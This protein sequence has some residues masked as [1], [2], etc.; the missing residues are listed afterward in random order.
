MAFGLAAKLAHSEMEK[1]TRR[2][3]ELRDYFLEALQKIEPGIIINGSLEQ[4]IVNNLNIVFP[5]ID[6]G[7]LLLSLH[8]LGVYVSSGS[9][10]SAGSKETSYVIKALGVD[11]ERYGIIRFSF[12]LP[13][14]K[15]EVEYLLKYLPSI[16]EQLKAEKI[17]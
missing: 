8:Q 10:C 5:N 3:S 14:T 17:N 4:R 1:E 13:N 16:L 9:A 6:S 7:S 2:L 12:G 15:E 11:T